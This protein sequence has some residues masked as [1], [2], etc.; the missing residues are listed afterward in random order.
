M[1][2][3]FVDG[4]SN[5]DDAP[6]INYMPLPPGRKNHM[7]PEGSSGLTMTCFHRAKMSLPC[8][9]PSRTRLIDEPFFGV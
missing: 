6:D 4:D 3:A 5:A 7:T 1:S 9:L 8:I 2:R